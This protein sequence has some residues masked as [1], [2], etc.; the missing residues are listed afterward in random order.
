MKEYPEFKMFGGTSEEEQESCWE[1]YSKR[2]NEMKQQ[3]RD[4]EYP[5]DKNAYIFYPQH[6]YHKCLVTEISPQK[7]L[8]LAKPKS[9]IR[10]CSLDFLLDA[11]DYNEPLIPPVYLSVSPNDCS[12]NG[13][14]GRHR[15][16][17][18]ND[19]GVKKIPISICYYGDYTLVKYDKMFGREMVDYD[20]INDAS[21]EMKAVYRKEK[22]GNLYDTLVGNLGD[23]WEFPNKCTINNLKKEGKSIFDGSKELEEVEQERGEFR[24]KYGLD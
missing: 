15:A 19:L 3:E 5:L 23:K 2:I 11:F 4:F 13:H 7:F 24:K 1:H 20:A 17:I 18:A 8:D 21:V 6:E 14:E 16:E 10:V 22:E 12:I 9:T